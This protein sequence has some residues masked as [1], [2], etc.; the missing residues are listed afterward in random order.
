MSCV[1]F[2]KEAPLGGGVPVFEEALRIGRFENGFV[3]L[4]AVVVVVHPAIRRHTLLRPLLR[5]L[6]L[7]IVSYAHA[8]VVVVSEDVLGTGLPQMTL[9]VPSD[10][11][12][13]S[14][15][16]RACRLVCL[17]S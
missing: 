17:V 9:T 15:G 14:E 11:S 6:V 1:R 16:G 4:V 2:L 7:V 13:L 5:D 12:R 10:F 3:G 8:L